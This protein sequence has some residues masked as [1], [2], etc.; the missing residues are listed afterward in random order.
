MYIE[1]SHLLAA[2]RNLESIVEFQSLLESCSCKHEL[3]NLSA[4]LQVLRTRL[5]EKNITP[6]A[7]QGGTAQIKSLKYC[8]SLSFSLF[9]LFKFS[10]L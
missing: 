9:F 6:D 4:L 7:E 8:V 5:T 1:H 2:R 3:I 10:S